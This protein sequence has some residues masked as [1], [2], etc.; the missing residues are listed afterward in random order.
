MASIPQ[1][2]PVTLPP[3][4]QVA[5]TLLA[6]MTELGLSTGTPLNASVV[7]ALPDGTTQLD[8]GGRML[9][10]ALPQG[11]A[12]G[13]KVQLSITG[14]PERP[15][16]ALSLPEA[17]PQA[18]ARPLPLPVTPHPLPQPLPQAVSQPAAPLPV[19][20]PPAAASPPPLP[21]PQVLLPQNV[22]QALRAALTPQPQGPA[23]QAQTASAPLP[24]R[25]EV[26][27]QLPNGN[28]RLAISGRTIE[29]RLPTPLPAGT[30]LTLTPQ[31]PQPNAPITVSVQSL[32]PTSVTQLAPQANAP[33][34]VT[35]TP[36]PGTPPLSAATPLSPQQVATGRAPPLAPAATSQPPAPSTPAAAAL[37]EAV[38]QAVGRQQSLAP[39]VT[40]LASLGGRLAS[41]PPPVVQAVQQLLAARVRADTPISAE[42]LMQAVAKSGVFLEAGL[43]TANPA[44]ATAGDTKAALLALRSGLSGLAGTQGTPVEAMQKAPP[45]LRG[46]PPR[47]QPPEVPP[48][49]PESREALARHLLSQTDGA[50]HRMRLSQAASL[51]DMASSLST[52]DAR[53][54]WNVEIP[55]LLGRE[56]AMLGLQVLRDGKPKNPKAGR[57]WQMRF[58]LNFSETGEVG[59]NVSLREGV[60]HVL[61]WAEAPETAE[62][63]NTALPEL[64]GALAAHG[65]VLGSV[66]CKTGAPRDTAVASGRLVDART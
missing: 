12:P 31:S 65:L 15:Q 62:A 49:L 56:L 3:Q 5:R 33:A 47:A 66:L 44:R 13:T 48:P 55:L 51:P 23:P 27:A 14:T 8:L 35:L 4:A 57:G 43:T 37:R 16:I 38:Q 40:T 63:I 39:L 25:A 20:A 36:P 22:P 41:L 19:T 28:T 30:A 24:V 61:I 46:L 64:T 7:G 1:T 42:K 9:K 34:P 2:P 10:L 54:E 21:A 18:A 53:A 52:P 11:L 58:A 45:P 60:T 59:A 29:V 32:P 50:L 26:V 6:M 17:P